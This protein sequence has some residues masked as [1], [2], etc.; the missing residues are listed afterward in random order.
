[1]RPILALLLAL[2]LLAPTAAAPA[3]PAPLAVTA[4]WDR[5]GAL[6]IAWTLPHDQQLA[7]A[8]RANGQLLACVGPGIASLTHGPAGIDARTAIALG[9]RVQVRVWDARGRVVATGTAPAGE[10]LF[11]PWMAR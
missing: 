7:C 10:Q 5:T 3:P 11:F 6:V 9:E 2:A 4:R 8:L 1:M